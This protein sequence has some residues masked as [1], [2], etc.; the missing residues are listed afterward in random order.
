MT[1]SAHHSPSTDARKGDWCQ[2]FTGRKMHPLDPR[3]EDFVIEDIAHALSR[4]ARF[5]GHTKGDLAYSVAQHSVLAA[6]H[7][8]PK[9]KLAALL[10]DASEAY[11]GDVPRP[12]KRHMHFD[13]DGE[14]VPFKVVEDRIQDAIHERFGVVVDD[15]ILAEVKAI[16]EA[17]LVT[18]A[19]D[20]MAPLHPDWSLEWL[21]NRTPLAERIVPWSA[22]TAKTAFLSVFRDLTENKETP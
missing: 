15:A 9:A 22:E 1:R 7:V 5:A 14:M 4:V 18:E 8:S 10:H 21:R 19:R 12:L 3:P 20:L 2:S 16:D 13:I 17:L 11:T 6:R